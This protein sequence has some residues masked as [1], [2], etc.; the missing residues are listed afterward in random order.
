MTAPSSGIK[1]SKPS[2]MPTG[3]AMSRVDQGLPRWAI[4]WATHQND[5]T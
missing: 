3:A 1:V 5:Q 2:S 4:W